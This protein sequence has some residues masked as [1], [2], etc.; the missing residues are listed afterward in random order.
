MGRAL[1]A[2]A[3]AAWA[4][5][6]PHRRAEEVPTI[7]DD[8][9]EVDENDHPIVQD[10]YDDGA[11]IQDDGAG[12]SESDQQLRAEREFDD[13]DES[14]D[15]L[16]AADGD[17]DGGG[18]PEGGVELSPHKPVE[19]PA[20]AGSR[21]RG[22]AAPKRLDAAATGAAAA[23]MMVDDTAAPPAAPEQPGDAPQPKPKKKSKA[24]YVVPAEPPAKLI[25]FFADL[26]TTSNQRKQFDRIIELG[27]VAKSAAGVELDR[28]GERFLNASPHCK[29][30][31]QPLLPATRERPEQLSWRRQTAWGCAGCKVN[32]CSWAC[33]VAYDHVHHC[34]TRGLTVQ[35]ARVKDVVGPPT[36]QAQARV[37]VGSP[38]TGAGPSRRGR[39]FGDEPAVELA[40]KKSNRGGARAGAGRPPGS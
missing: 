15:V 38:A 36:E 11:G 40:P 39:S 12:S 18:G 33:F 3:S 28:W 6:V 13:E 14:L 5:L 24:E 27:V 25:Y 4:A 34:S 23:A 10:D 20:A 32:I 16:E 29:Q 21:K 35:Y 2:L 30:C 19:Q 9:D 7:P 8:V 22:K 31:Y 17:G 1:A 26:E 37:P